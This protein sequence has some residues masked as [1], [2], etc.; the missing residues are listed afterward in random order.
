ML[1][2]ATFGGTAMA[3]GKFKNS[4]NRVERVVPRRAH[5]ASVDG[6]MPQVAN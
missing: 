4:P 2:V 6:I 5:P 3:A 1:M